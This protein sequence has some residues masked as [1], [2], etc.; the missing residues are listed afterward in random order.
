MRLNAYSCI[1]VILVLVGCGG[2]TSPI[3][4]PTESIAATGGG[5]QNT[6]VGTPFVTQL[7][8]SV[9]SNGSL[10]SGVTVTFAAPTSGASGTFS[11]GTNMATAMTD[12]SGVASV[13]FTAGSTAGA[14][15]V[16]A[17][18]SGASTSANFSLTNTAG[19][20]AAIMATGGASQT[21]AID[22]TFAPYWQPWWT[23]SRIQLAA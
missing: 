18:V 20:T 15:S 12:A 4:P 10:V 17:T 6:V 22:A 23:A 9:T 3:S 2:S 13:A 16:R 8:A 19:P 1:L 11:N 7:E 14:Y 21:V 5:G